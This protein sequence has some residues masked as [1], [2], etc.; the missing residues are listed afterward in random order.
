MCVCR[1]YPAGA[2]MYDDGV[3]VKNISNVLLDELWS[4][5]LPIWADAPCP[6]EEDDDAACVPA[7]L[8]PPHRTETVGVG[9][10][11]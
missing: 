6:E 4:W 1:C 7:S 9:R 2:A 11:S 8:L 5:D 10:V 3:L